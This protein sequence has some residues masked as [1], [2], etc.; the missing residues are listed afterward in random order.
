LEVDGGGD[1]GVS[2]EDAA[3]ILKGDVGKVV[4][5]GL[6]RVDARGVA[7]HFVEHERRRVHLQKVEPQAALL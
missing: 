3:G 5:R 4:R 7:V 2:G 1:G 6:V